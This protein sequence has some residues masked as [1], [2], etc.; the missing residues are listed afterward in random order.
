MSDAKN[1]S[2]NWPTSAETAPV[3]WPLNT[4]DGAEWNILDATGTRVAMC[5][6]DDYGPKG[7]YESGRMIGP[8]IVGMLRN[9]HAENAVLRARVAELEERASRAEKVVA[10]VRHSL[11]CAGVW[12]MGCSCQ[13]IWLEA[14]ADA[15]SAYDMTKEA[16]K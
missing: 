5:G 11:G 4:Q 12:K 7:W 3:A 8:A 14:M 6:Y 9:L 2:A 15:M 10:S 13:R 1:D 16:M